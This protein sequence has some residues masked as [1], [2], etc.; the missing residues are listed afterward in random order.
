MARAYSYDLRLKVMEFIGVGKTIKEASLV[1][2]ISRKT[3]MEWK[4]LKRETGDINAKTGYHRGHR[5]KIKDIEKFKRFVEEN[6]DK[7]SKE[8]ARNWEQK[9]SPSAIIRL[10]HKLGYSYK[11]NILSSQKGFWGA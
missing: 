9:V 10:L 3:I 11:K 2:Q 4:K 6:Y 5:R 8:L 1:F 7:S